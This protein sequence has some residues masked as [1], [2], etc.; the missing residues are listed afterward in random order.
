MR[1]AFIDP[2]SSSIIFVCDKL[3]F[4]S[5]R[6]QG[7]T[8]SERARKIVRLQTEQF[9][10]ALEKV[11]IVPEP[12]HMIVDWSYLDDNS[13]YAEFLK[14]LNEAIEGDLDLKRRRVEFVSQVLTRASERFEMISPLSSKFEIEYITE[15]TA[16]SLYMTEIVGFNAEIYRRGLGFVDYIYEEKPGILK[17]LLGRA[18]M[19]KQ[20]IGPH[21]LD[22]HKRRLQTTG[23]CFAASSAGLFKLQPLFVD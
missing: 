1:E 9:M 13:R 17:R 2:S 16:L 22:R 11:G 7:E 19:L 20:F 21:S 15:E 4:L 10:R 6:V 5:Y 18:E 14:D 23:S 12:N 8:D 3:R